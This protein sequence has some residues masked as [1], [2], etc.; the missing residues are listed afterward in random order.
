MKFEDLKELGSESAVKV[1]YLI[2]WPMS[3]ATPFITI[4]LLSDTWWYLLHRPLGST[5]RKGRHTLSRTGTLFSS[6]STS[7]AVGRSEI[8]LLHH[9]P[10]F[11]YQVEKSDT[12]IVTYIWLMSIVQIS[13]SWLEILCCTSFASWSQIDIIISIF[14]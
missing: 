10:I 6:S 12:V 11:H 7:L 14:S 1:E 3:M 13:W 5:G 9:R 8:F 4:S 2:Q